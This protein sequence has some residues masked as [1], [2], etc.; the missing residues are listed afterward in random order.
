MTTLRNNKGWLTPAGFASGLTERRAVVDPSDNA[1]HEARIVK[2]GS[3]YIASLVIT[4]GRTILVVRHHPP[5][6][7]VEARRTFTKITKGFPKP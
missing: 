7:L 1:T 4:R 6:T 5:S 2:S 3:D